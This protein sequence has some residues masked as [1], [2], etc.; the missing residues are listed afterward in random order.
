MTIYTKHVYGICPAENAAK[1]NAL[2]Q[3]AGFGRNNFAAA[4][5]GD[6][7]RNAPSHYATHWVMTEAD[8]ERLATDPDLAAFGVVWD[9]SRGKVGE[10]PNREK[11]WLAAARLKKQ[12]ATV[13]TANR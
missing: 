2:L 4:L 10:D 1:V 13:E 11:D 3:A 7:S 6:G 5:N 12:A 9:A 8:Y